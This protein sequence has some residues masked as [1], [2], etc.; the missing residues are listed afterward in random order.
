MRLNISYAT[1][2]KYVKLVATSMI[3]LFENNNEFTEIYV[4]I[5]E[6]NISESSKKELINIALKYKRNVEFIELKEICNGLKTDNSFPISSFSRLFLSNLTNID[7]I[8]YLD[9]DSI[10]NNSFY[11]LWNENIEDYYIAGVLDT[12]NSFYKTTVGL[13]HES[14]YINAGLLLINLK[15]WRDDKIES[16][17]LDFINLY[18]GS[19]PHHDQGTLNAICNDKIYILHPKYNLMPPMLIYNENKIKKLYS[20]NQYYSQKELDEAS[21]NPVF[22]HFTADFYNRPWFKECSHPMKNIF[23]KYFNKTAWKYQF[24]DKKLTKN[25]RIMYLLYKFLPFKIYNIINKFIAYRKH[26]RIK[27]KL[28]RSKNDESFSKCNSTYL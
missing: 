25:A 15:K 9:C 13:Q 19:V 16:K 24:E 17:F 20:L 12:I 1:D 14:N 4:Y 2:E 26:N 6:N 23:L 7:K 10:V 11:D 28:N 27:L 5:I 21:E 8:I 22:I 18:N 3:S